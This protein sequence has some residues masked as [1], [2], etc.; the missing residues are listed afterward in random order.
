MSA[1]IAY[2][3]NR[4]RGFG[5]WQPYERVVLLNVSG[6]RD[7]LV[8]LAALGAWTV[9]SG[10]GWPWWWALPWAASTA[11]FA[12]LLSADFIEPVLLMLALGYNQNPNVM[13]TGE[14]ERYAGATD[15]A[16]RDQ[17][18]REKYLPLVPPPNPRW[19]GDPGPGHYPYPRPWRPWFAPGT[20]LAALF[21]HD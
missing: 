7:V 12:A 6:V 11:T 1:L 15:V 2:L 9:A 20:R 18:E 5:S 21:V 10:Q 8:G 19:Q 16:Y 14:K 17:W 13:A 4:L 3:W